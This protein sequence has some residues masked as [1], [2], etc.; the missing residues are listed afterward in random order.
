MNPT[1]ESFTAIE[2]CDS[3]TPG[4][5]G[6]VGT[7][8][9]WSFNLIAEN[10]LTDFATIAWAPGSIDGTR[11]DN[12]I[13]VTPT[14]NTTIYVKYDGKV[15]GNTGL[16]SPCGMRYDVSY[17]LNVLNHKRLLDATDKD[18][19]GLAVYT[20]DGTKLAAVY[21][22][23]ASTATTGNPSWDVGSTIQ[24]FCKQKLIFA[25]DDYARTMVSQ[26]VTIPILIN[27]FGFLAVVDPSSVNNTALLQPR[28]GIVSINANGTVIYTPNPGYIG[29]D[30]FEYSV[31]STPT[32]VVC[33][34]AL[35]YID[36]SSC[37]APFNQNVLAGKVF[38]DKNDDGINNDGGTGV[39]GGKVYLYVDGNCNTIIDPN[40]LKDSVIVDAS[41]TYQFITYPEKF[42][43]DDFDGTGGI[44]TCA[45]GSDGNAAWI[46]NWTDIGDPSAGFCNNSQTPA[47]TD[48]EIV[49]DGAFSYALRLKDNNVSATRT[50]DLT[51]ASYAF[52]SFSY[53]RKSATLTAGEDVIVQASSNGSTFGTIFTIAGD[54][55]T[56]AGYVNIYN[57][58]ITAFAAPVT[59]IRF[60]TNNS[61]DDADTV[62]IDN[63]KVQFLKYP[64]CYI[65]RLDPA[66]VPAYHHTTT[67]LQHNLTASAS[68]TCLSP[69]DF[70]IAKNIIPVSGTLFLDAN[71]N[72]DGQVNG[73][74]MGTVS[75]APV[76]GYLVDSTGKVA[77]RTMVN[78]GTGNYIFPNADVLTNYNLRL[79]VISVNLGDTPPANSG[80]AAL[81][82]NWINTGDA[83]GIN[84][85][86]GTGL[87][88]GTAT[89]SI[90]VTTGIVS[91]TAVNFGIER[92]PGSDDRVINYPLNT[93][94]LL[95]N[96]T[97]GLTGT[98]PEDGVLG[99]GN[100]YKI[101]GLPVGAVLFYNNV[102]VTLNQVISSFNPGLLKIDPD[103]DTHTTLFTYA[104]RDAA[105]LYDPTPATV[106]V[107]W[108]M[109]LPV[110]LI[111]FSGRL[112]GSKVDLNWVTANEL[113]TK[114]FEVER[115]GDGQVFTKI[116]TVTAKGNSNT[117]T[118]YDLVDPAPLK[119]VNY[120]RLKIVDIDGKFE[121]SQVIIIRIENSIQ[122]VTKVAPNPFT[123]K[124]D[125]YLTLTHNTPVDFR[126]IDINGRLV[127]SKSVNGLKGFNWFTINDLDRLQS[128]PY[129][130]HIKT[131]DAV[132]VEKLI[133]Q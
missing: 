74:P 107:N 81:A 130:L 71:G 30:T 23:D 72:T 111:S 119:G 77:K 57:Q 100:T 80:I 32:P 5:G 95:Y 112:N 89:T 131:D 26:P 14:A 53:R 19:S 70:G 10:R 97:G 118:S 90:P 99:T 39:A 88:P 110:K 73:T 48:A 113:N 87:K 16:V 94:D 33:D 101:T 17:P 68:A 104:S 45:S 9:D 15:S 44:N 18:Q 78:A 52:L 58:D 20:C 13:W 117:P 6:N 105:G 67:I 59:Y 24:P 4:S 106:I 47:N 133:K 86:A 55:N 98:D 75:S 109:T 123:G 115:S 91:I 40:E 84:N 114:Q 103:D 41:G 125:V 129:M 61:V 121:Y 46:G 128:A 54:G 27:D 126:F 25:N 64:Q 124:I 56:D 51:G 83:F 65:T 12:P 31:C 21:G 120:Y 127:F 1:G 60:L 62:Y 38:L 34:R 43:A 82:G 42:V 102:S 36:I 7:E 66:T 3:Y 22:E 69:Y 2:I 11:N 92:L 76:Y 85:N 35:V 8:F 37:P 49:K 93:P 108:A 116:A 122:L 29:K 79:S 132:I 96:V 28:N 50:V 63:V